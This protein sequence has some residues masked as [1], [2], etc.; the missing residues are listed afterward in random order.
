MSLL[1]KSRWGFGLGAAATAAAVILI[2]TVSAPKVQAK[3][4]DVMARGAQ[5]VAKLTSIHLRGQ[6][7]TLPADNFEY[8]DAERDFY[9]IELWKQLKP[10]LK[11]RV[12]KPGRIAVMDGQQT[13]LYIKPGKVA[14]KFPRPSPSAPISTPNIP[15]ANTTWGGLRIFTSR[16]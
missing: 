16:P 14:A 13:V 8:I 12:E 10:E 7:R 5:A 2:T 6:L 4:A 9:P 3:A 15:S 11:W 1:F